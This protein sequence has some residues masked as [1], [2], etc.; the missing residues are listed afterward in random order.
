M[1]NKPQDQKTAQKLWESHF[2]IR[3]LGTVLIVAMMNSLLFMQKEA[4]IPMH[5]LIL[6]VIAGIGLT[7]FFEKM[8]KKHSRPKVNTEDEK[9]SSQRCDKVLG[10]IFWGLLAFAALLVALAVLYKEI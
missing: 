3:L 10:W 7:V 5:H 8:R 6:S 4:F 9:K 2:S 1:P